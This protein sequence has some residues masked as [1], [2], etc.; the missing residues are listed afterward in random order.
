MFGNGVKYLF[1]QYTTLVLNTER[2]SEIQTSGAL[3][4]KIKDSTGYS[5][6]SLVA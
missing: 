6:M 4:D 2:V 1:S 3:R 5:G